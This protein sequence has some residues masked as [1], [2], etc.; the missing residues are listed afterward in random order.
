[1]ELVIAFVMKAKEQHE[2][3]KYYFK[4][5][6]LVWTLWVCIQYKKNESGHKF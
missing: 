3:Q 1:M 2:K 5:Y 6:F 4:L